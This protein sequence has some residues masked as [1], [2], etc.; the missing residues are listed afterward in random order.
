MSPSCLRTAELKLIKVGTS[1]QNKITESSNAGSDDL[2][3]AALPSLYL[4]VFLQANLISSHLK[5]PMTS[6]VLSSLPS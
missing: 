6:Y 2:G 3:D 5:I 1:A 4:H